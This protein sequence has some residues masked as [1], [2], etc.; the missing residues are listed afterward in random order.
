MLT[1]SSAEA[2]PKLRSLLG[3][4]E[5]KS[6]GGES[7]EGFSLVLMDHDAQ[8][9]LPDLLALEREKLLNVAG[10][11]ILLVSR[12]RGAEDVAAVLEHVR[13]RPRSYCV[14]SD[15]HCVVEIFY[16]KKARDIPRW[17]DGSEGNWSRDVFVPSK[18]L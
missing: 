12:K 17:T 6:S 8:R 9:Y 7:G 18:V 2:I 16:R 10:C 4:S 5:R 14:T 3:A 13:T 1:S 15:L 11:S